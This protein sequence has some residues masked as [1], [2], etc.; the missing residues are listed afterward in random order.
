MNTLRKMFFALAL[1]ASGLTI[2]AQEATEDP[3]VKYAA[4]LLKPE[5]V[6]P[7]FKILN[8]DNAKDVS[9]SQFRGQFVVVEFWASWCPD[10]RKDIPE[11][12]KLVE[13]YGQ[14]GVKFIGVSFDTDKAAWQSC[15][16]KNG[17]NWLHGSELK[18]WKNGTQ[19]DK[20]YKVNWIPTYYLICPEGKVILGTVQH[21]KI[22]AKLANLEAN[23]LLK[24]NGSDCKNDSCGMAK[25]KNLVSGMNCK[26]DSCGMTKGKACDC[27]M[28]CK[29]GKAGMDNGKACTNGMN[30][31]E[32]MNG[33]AEGKV[34]ASS[35]NCKKD[36]C[37]MAKGKAC[38]CGMKCKKDNTAMCKG[39]ACAADK[40][41]KKQQAA[42]KASKKTVTKKK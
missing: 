31:K 18:K 17:M 20:D 16:E 34:C 36:S 14:K 26:K 40:N 42:T 38:D 29:K 4:E 28:K 15:I 35:M 7:D 11:V 3:D 5:T 41:C 22:A 13:N 12:K 25:G 19:I 39:K 9:L 27:G 23:G 24:V 30:C 10:C 21:Q 2:A 32:H 8:N 1:L 6:A 33:M 37:G